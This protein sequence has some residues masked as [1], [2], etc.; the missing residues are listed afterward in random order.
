MKKLKRLA[1][2]TSGGDAPGMNAAIRAVVLTALHHQL[3]VIGFTR[4]YNGLI[5]GEYQVLTED[6]VEQL[7]GKGGTI[8][9]SARCAEFTTIQGQHKA[10]KILQNLAIDCLIVIGGDGS[11]RGAQ[12]FASIW[13][14]QIIGIPG[15]IDNDVAGSDK[16]IGF[17]TA[18]D[19]AV[20]AI[21]KIRDTADAFERIF[22][23]E[24]MGRHSGFIAMNVAIA[25]SAE[26]VLTFESNQLPSKQLANIINHIANAQATR[27]HASYIIVVAENLWPNGTLDLAKVL[28]TQAGIECQPCI[29]G[30]IQRGG[31]PVYQDRILATKLGIAAVEAALDGADDVMMGEVA[32]RIKATPLSELAILQKHI[33]EFMFNAQQCIF[34]HHDYR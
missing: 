15:T 27:G 23:V 25:T 30:H 6:D 31:S 19:T 14:G 9:K 29:L 28:S 34:E 17:A 20:D 22:L 1:I 8:L 33:D 7:I 5:T 26:Q 11:F 2:L 24:V 12:A 16:T 21:D 18:V 3:E 32:N 4:G 13:H 10:A